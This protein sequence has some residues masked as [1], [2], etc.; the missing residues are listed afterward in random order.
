[1]ARTADDC[2]GS[3][4]AT[5]TS[6]LNPTSNEFD[7]AWPLGFAGGDAIVEWC[8]SPRVVVSGVSAER[9]LL[10]GAVGH[11]G[12]RLG[13]VLPSIERRKRRPREGTL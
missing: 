9:A 4:N 6:H 12:A 7:G 11:P 3:F 2:Q 5:T 8:E 1:M 10:P 13:V